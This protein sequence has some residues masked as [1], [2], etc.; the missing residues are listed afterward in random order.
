MAEHPRDLVLL[1][2]EAERLSQDA[3]WGQQDHPDGTSAV[4]TETAERARILCSVRHAEG[5]GT[6][7][8]ILLEEVAEACA[9]TD[10]AK[11]REELIQV[12]AV[13]VA[14]IEAIDRRPA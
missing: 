12:A 6:W 5:V 13:A 11:L 10:P 1:Q 3:K 7:N 8:L 14:W 9:E 4:Y 2:I